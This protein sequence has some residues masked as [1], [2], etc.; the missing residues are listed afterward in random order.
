MESSSSME[1]LIRS[2]EKQMRG[3]STLTW[4]EDSEECGERP[5]IGEKSSGSLGS[6]VDEDWMSEGG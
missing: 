3:E 4:G 5:L 6:S 1:S 2:G